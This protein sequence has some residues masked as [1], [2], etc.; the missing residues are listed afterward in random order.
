MGKKIEIEEELIISLYLG[1][2]YSIKRISRNLGCSVSP[3]KRILKENDIKIKNNSE[4]QLGIP[5]EEKGHKEDCQCGVCKNKRGEF[6]T[7]ELRKKAAESRIGMVFTEERRRKIS[8]ALTGKKLSEERIEKMRET[9]RELWNREGFR[10]NFISKM[11]GREPWNKGIYGEDSHTWKGGL[12][13]REYSY[14]WS[15]IRNLALEYYGD[16]CYMCGKQGNTS[17]HHIDY[18]KQDNKIDNLIPLC[19]VC[20]SKTNWHREIWYKLFCCN[21]PLPPLESGFGEFISNHLSNLSEERE[22]EIFYSLLS[23]A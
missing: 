22:E 16:I 18:D 1:N 12:S 17:I 10:E 13:Y 6:W 5:L 2:G 20:H 15:E 11:K 9:T 4:S 23:T 14:N 19:R 3:I 21:P 8:V 7:P